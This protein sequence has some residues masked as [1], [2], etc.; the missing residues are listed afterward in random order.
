[1]TTPMK[2]NVAK[3]KT[4]GIL[5]LDS[6]FP[7]I[8]GDVGSPNTFPFP[9]KKLI[10]KGAS[11]QRVVL[12]GDYALLEPFIKGALELEREG[13]DAIT[14]SCGFMAMFQKE[15]AEKVH[16]PLFT[17][18]LLQVSLAYNCL[19]PNKCVG[20]LT[21]DSR[22]L[23][24]RHFK[25]AGIDQIPKVVYGMEGSHFHDIF[26]KNSEHLNIQQA[27]HDVVGIAKRMVHEHP[28]VGAI[29]LEC[30]NMPPYAYAVATVTDMPVYDITTLAAYVMAGHF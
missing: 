18:S 13:V 24:E 25:G 30:T 5:M 7:R 8:T 3:E 14:T 17:S 4:L 20:I 19:P 27:Q 12:E 6:K 29:V 21:A 9:V 26:V 10:I 16:I 23:S 15:L 1:M 11:P 28:E 22:N 2:K